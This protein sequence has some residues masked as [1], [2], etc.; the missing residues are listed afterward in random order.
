MIRLRSSVGLRLQPT[1]LTPP[2]LSLDESSASGIKRRPPRQ[3]NLASLHPHIR[4]N[5]TTNLLILVPTTVSSGTPRQSSPSQ[6]F[7]PLFK[8]FWGGSESGWNLPRYFC[9]TLPGV[10][11]P[12]TPSLTWLIVNIIFFITISPQLSATINVRGKC[13]CNRGSGRGGEGRDK[14]FKTVFL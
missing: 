5:N 10:W 1:L 4:L 8:T 7:A 14:H 3:S 12:S 6:K 13:D 11:R 2:Q 9:K